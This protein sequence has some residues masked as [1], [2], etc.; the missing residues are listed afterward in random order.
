MF[1]IADCFPLL[2]ELD[3]SNPIIESEENYESLVNGVKALSSKLF[4]LR[5]VNL[6]SHIYINDELLFHLFRNWKF[7]EEAIILHC[8]QI[9]N[10]GVTS[11]LRERPTLRSLSFNRYID[12][13][14]NS[15]L[16]A[17]VN[18]GPLLREIS[19]GYAWKY[20]VENS[21]TPMDV[22]LLNLSYCRNISDKDICEVLTT[23]LKIVHLDLTGCSQLKLFGSN[24]EVPKLEVL[25]LSHANVDDK[26]L[27]VISKHCRGLMQLLLKCCNDVAMKGLQQVIENCTQSREINLS[28]CCNVDANVVASMVFSSP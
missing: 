2:E 11:S 5:K 20:G 22:A 17:L 28:G 26:T 7:L 9:T 24:F 12:L 3:L 8:N 15:T 6:T 27:Y 4:K 13:S 18:N 14:D 19:L 25:N 21:N 23:C 16:F 10:A 1:L